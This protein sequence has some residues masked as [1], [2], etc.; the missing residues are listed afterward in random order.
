MAKP[1][2]SVIASVSRPWNW[3]PIYKNLM[4]GTEFPIEFI[5]V[6]NKYPTEDVPGNM[7]I[8]FSG[9]KPTQ[10]VEF[11][12]R[13]ASGKYI[14]AIADDVTFSPGILNKLYWYAERIPN[15]YTVVTGRFKY[16]GNF[17]DEGL[18]LYKGIVSPIMA[19][20][21]LIHTETWREIGGI[22]KQFVAV[23]WD[24]DMYMRLY[25]LG[26]SVFIAP[27]TLIEEFLDEKQ[28]GL[29]LCS[30]E[31]KEKDR[32]CLYPMYSV[33]DAGYK[34]RNRPVD[35]F[36]DDDFAEHLFLPT[37]REIRWGW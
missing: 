36:T 23:Y 3:L 17:I 13:K 10:C 6:G 29:T 15:K 28:V 33:T 12:A 7:E 37:S 21:P 2:I 11:A 35:S 27:D 34:K 22:D 31:Y 9:V 30:D 20:C 26:G 5:F 14:F 24:Y 8:Y 32:G 19:V 25:A 18:V 16:R 4:E 1:V